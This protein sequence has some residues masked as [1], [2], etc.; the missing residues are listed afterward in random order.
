MAGEVRQAELESDR[1]LRQVGRVVLTLVA[2]AALVVAAFVDW[3]PQR[4]GDELTI[5]A[6]VGTNFQSQGDF[7]KTAGA[8]TVLVALVALLGLVDRTGWLTRLT[9]AAA[10]IMFVLFA[11]Q[12]YRYFGHDASAAFHHSRTGVWL[13]V[14]SGLLLLIGG[15]LGARVV[16]VPAVVDTDVKRP[17][18]ARRGGRAERVDDIDDGEDAEDVKDAK[19][20]ARKD[21]KAARDHARAARS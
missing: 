9:G 15:F 11:V 2:V 5:K 10:L 20:D 4:V 14:G 6:L 13:L 1:A 21:A 3:V 7:V 12:A 17:A 8:L 18:R 16:A 19:K